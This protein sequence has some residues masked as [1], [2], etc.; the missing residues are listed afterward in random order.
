MRATLRIRSMLLPLATLA[1]VAAQLVQPSPAWK[2]LL[3]VFAGLWL[4]SYLWARAL[5]RSLSFTRAMRF[6]WAQVGDRLE[7]QFVVQN[8]SVFP[9][10]W[11]EVSDGS[12]LPGYSVRRATGVG[13]HSQ[14]EWTTEGT[15][16]RRGVF[17]LGDTILST[18]DP[19]G[20]YRMEI[21]QS[22]TVTLT[23]MPP[24]IRLP[25]HQVTAG[26]WQG[27]GRPRPNANEHTPSA[28]SVRVYLHGDSLRLIH[29]PTTARTGELYVRTLEGAPASD[30]WI[31]LDLEACVQ[32]GDENES[33]AELGIIVAASL[34]ERGLRAHRS[35]GLIAAGAQPIWMRPEAGEKQR[36]QIMRSLAMAENGDKPLAAVLERLGPALG[37]DANLAV[38][39]PSSEGGWITALARLV[40]RGV[41]ATAILIDPGTFSDKPDS[42][43]R[44]L[45]EILTQAGIPYSIVGRDLFRQPEARPGPAG[46]W[47]WRTLPTGKAV[48]VRRPTDMNWKHFG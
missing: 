38:I 48:P 6:G 12:T 4:L 13:G 20:I 14:N 3:T 28:E 23:V 33:T 46:Q 8:E 16:T 34:A 18:G 36:W 10:T 42:N 24:V 2:G 5:Q 29:W 41:T 1:L 25:F 17:T 7:E 9:A 27:D 22:E 11:L 30:W 39:T 47:E 26:G 32:A 40:T 35:V 15:C 37:S 19:L 31:A 21:K 43:V 45:A 44:A